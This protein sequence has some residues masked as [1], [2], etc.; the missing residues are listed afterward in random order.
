VGFLCDGD[1]R[2]RDGDGC[3]GGGE[4]DCNGDDWDDADG[5]GAVKGAASGTNTGAPDGE[6]RP[7]R[8]EKQ[9]AWSAETWARAGEAGMA[10]ESSVQSRKVSMSAVAAAAR[11][12][13][14]AVDARKRS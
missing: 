6:K 14:P 8:A 1:D 13:K 10:G 7:V 11:A 4:G 12:K 3:D 9:S 5:I 2:D